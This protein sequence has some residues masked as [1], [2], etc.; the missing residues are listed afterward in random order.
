MFQY[1]SGTEGA[2]Q[3]YSFLELIGFWKHFC[4]N[5]GTISMGRKDGWLVAGMVRTETMQLSHCWDLA[6]H[7]RFA[8]LQPRQAGNKGGILEPVQS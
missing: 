3:Y 4:T 5:V 6:A 7:P 1:Q 8:P 2:A